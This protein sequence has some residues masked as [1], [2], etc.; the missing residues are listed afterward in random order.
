MLVVSLR[1]SFGQCAPQRQPKDQQIEG[2]FRE[3]SNC[4]FAKSSNVPS[5]LSVFRQGVTLVH[6]KLQ[7][8][9][10]TITCHFVQHYNLEA[11]HGGRAVELHCHGSCPMHNFWNDYISGQM[12]KKKPLQVFHLFPFRACLKILRSCLIS[13]SRILGFRAPCMLANL[14]HPEVHRLRVRWQN[15]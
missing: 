9:P 2:Q 13:A 5:Y 7:I 1:Q 4:V 3:S 12:L 11:Q 8:Q 14:Q 10:N 15:G 6:W